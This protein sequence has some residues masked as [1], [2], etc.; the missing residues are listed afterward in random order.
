MAVEFH[1]SEFVNAEQ[2]DTSVAG[3]RLVQLLLVGGL[4][5]FVNQLGGE[6]V[7]DAVALHRG[8]GAE[9]DE[10]VGLAGA[11]VADQAERLGSS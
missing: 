5:Q 11:G 2:I 6:G 9:R 4:D 8:L 3:D 1:V 7:A 10:H